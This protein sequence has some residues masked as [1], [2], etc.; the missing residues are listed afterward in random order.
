MELSKKEKLLNTLGAIAR[1]FFF[2]TLILKN[3]NIIRLPI[4]IPLLLLLF[5]GLANGIS[6]R[7][8]NKMSAIV[9]FA[10]CGLVA[11]LFLFYIFRKLGYL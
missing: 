7:K 11:L 5:S 10:G 1:L 9:E 6:L 2:I 3:S 4:T 8:H